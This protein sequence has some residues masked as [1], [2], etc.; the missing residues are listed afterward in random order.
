MV[1]QRKT[2]LVSSIQHKIQ[3]FKAPG[4]IVPQQA[5]TVEN[6]AGKFYIS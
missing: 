6:K 3:L 5:Q 4:I 1:K 2:K